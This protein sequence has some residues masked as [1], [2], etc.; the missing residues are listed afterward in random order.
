MAGVRYMMFTNKHH[1]GFAMFD[2]ATTTFGVMHT[3]FHRDTTAEV[4]QAFRDRKIFRSASIF[5]PT[6]S[7]WLRKQGKP[8]L[9]NV[10][11]VQPKNNPG[12]M[13]YDQAQVRELFTK[14]GPIQSGLFRRA[15]GWIA[16]FGM[17]AATRHRS[18]PPCGAVQTRLS[19]MC[20]ECLCREHGRPI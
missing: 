8:V 18:L 19:N 9:R 2:T 11:E 6:I 10:P 3:P 17:E 7:P 12:L 15:D 13:A 14:Y 20:R 5:L 4:F 1:S 16:R